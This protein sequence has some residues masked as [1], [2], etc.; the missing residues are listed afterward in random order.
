MKINNLLA[1]LDTVIHKKSR[2]QLP[3]GQNNLIFQFAVPNA[4]MPQIARFAYRLKQDEEWVDIGTQNTIN[5]SSLSPDNYVLEVRAASYDGLW[6]EKTARLYF[7]ILPPWWRSWWAFVL[8]TLTVFGATYWF[9]KMQLR[10]KLERQEAQRLQQLDTF[11][12][13]FFANISH[14]FR[15]PLTMLI[16]PAENALNR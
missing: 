5:L 14:E 12:T 16:G 15:T 8:Y 6:S 9:Y 7:T 2:L 1:D 11:K 10:Q 4:P 13:R 3:Y